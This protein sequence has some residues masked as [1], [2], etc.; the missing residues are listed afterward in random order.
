[1]KKL[2]FIICIF[3]LSI[4]SSFAVFFIDGQGDY[5]A[6]GES[7]P[8]VGFGLGI[9][10]GL[11]DDV[12]FLIR[13]SAAEV[14]EDKD[15]IKETNYSYSFA[16]GGIEYIP[17]IAALDQYRISWKNSLSIGASMFEVDQRDLNKEESEMGVI[18]SLKTGLQ[19]NF[20]QT[21]A[22][23]FDLGYHK[24]F[25]SS[26]SDLSV[27]GWQVAFGVRFFIFGNKD[28]DTGY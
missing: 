18:A 6:T 16:T 23:Y 7:D 17:S 21:V 22:P 12:N 19:F 13:C 2:L 26:T 27:T 25:Y 4:T 1:L 28:Y 20:T 24:S 5:I 9:G 11:T 14:T 15:T 10:F 3:F 8:A